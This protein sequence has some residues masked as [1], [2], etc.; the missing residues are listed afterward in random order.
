MRLWLIILIFYLND[1]VF[2]GIYR[3]DY[4]WAEPAL[5][6]ADYAFRIAVLALIFTSAAMYRPINTS[7][8]L[9]RYDGTD[10]V[11]D[12][13]LLFLVY[14][15]IL[16]F[17]AL[18]ALSGNASETEKLWELLFRFQ[19]GPNYA[20]RVFDLTVGLLL[21][22]IVEELVFRKLLLDRLKARGFRWWI[23]IP[24]A[25]IIFAM[26]HW[27]GGTITVF[28]AGIFGVAWGAFYWV[29]GRVGA[30]IVWHYLANLHMNFL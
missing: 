20:L 3:S 10:S 22:A 23:A 29:R 15:L 18:T 28:V 26:M 2:I 25:T 27:G 11:K 1:F 13:G 12:F 14:L 21:V 17:V 7:L 9:E 30:L 24:L 19:A 5:L 6:V 16:P 4:T 8:A